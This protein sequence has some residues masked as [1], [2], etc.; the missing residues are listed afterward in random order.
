MR[1]AKRND[2]C[3]CN[4]GK[5]YKKCCGTDDTWMTTPTTL[6]GV[7]SL[8][9]VHHFFLFWVDAS[10]ELKDTM[11]RNDDGKVLV[12]MSRAASMQYGNNKF[13]IQ[14]KKRE[15]ISAGMGDVKWKNFVEEFEYVI[16]DNRGKEVCI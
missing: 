8:V 14:L 11:V 5:K 6:P 10:K 9:K 12:F 7:D 3:P 1:I 16:V 4:S 13:A 2:P 15:I